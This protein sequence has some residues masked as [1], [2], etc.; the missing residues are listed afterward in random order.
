NY[1][2]FNKEQVDMVFNVTGSE[3]VQKELPQFFSENT[4]IIPGS[5][6]NALVRLLIEK[7]HLISL[8]SEES[9]KQNIIFNSIEEGMI[10]IDKDGHVNFMNRSAARMVNVDIESAI[11]RPV[12]E[13]ISSSELS[14]I[15]ET[16]RTELNREL[17]LK[18]GTKI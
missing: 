8:L 4:V 2:D 3:N 9:H 11:G 12:N 5:I 14:R 1:R 17:V 15:Y 13:I 18:N 16:A 6:A 7:E 10:G